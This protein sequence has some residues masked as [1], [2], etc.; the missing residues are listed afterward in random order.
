MPPHP[1]RQM[2]RGA[3][4]RNRG[5]TSTDYG[6]GHNERSET[7]YPGSRWLLAALC[8]TRGRVRGGN[9]RNAHNLHRR[10]LRYSS[11]CRCKQRFQLIES[12][13]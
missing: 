5:D 10:R 6:Q 4:N 13:A 2:S 11:T 7:R 3:T 8:W 9:S 12:H 1:S